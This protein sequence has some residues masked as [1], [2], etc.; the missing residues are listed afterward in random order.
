M[1]EIIDTAGTEQFMAM[2]DLYM[3]NGQGF[4]LIFSVTSSA[5]FTDLWEMHKRL[6][7]VKDT[8]EVP[9]IL[10]GNKSDMS[11]MRTVTSDQAIEMATK[12]G[13]PFIETSAKLKVNVEKIFHDLVLEIIRKTPQKRDEVKLKKWN[14]HHKCSLL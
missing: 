9:A 6:V 2:R 1:L 14:H 11:T 12:F 8:E 4:L 10:V 7:Q 3:R 13:C 5:T